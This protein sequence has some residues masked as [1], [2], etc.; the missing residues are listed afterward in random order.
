MTQYVLNC[1]CMTCNFIKIKKNKV[2]LKPQ[3]TNYF[4]FQSGNVLFNQFQS[5]HIFPSL[6]YN[7][8]PKRESKHSNYRFMRLPYTCI[9]Q[10]NPNVNMDI[11]SLFIIGTLYMFGCIYFLL[12][13]VRFNIDIEQEILSGLP[14]FSFF[15]ILGQF[16]W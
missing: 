4:D 6:K 8:H 10:S 3:K 16:W 2:F 1:K 14:L 5:V 12:R 7:N 9:K 15:T 11:V 13:N